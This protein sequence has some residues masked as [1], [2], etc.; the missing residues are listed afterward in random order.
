MHCTAHIIYIIRWRQ[1]FELPK[2]S[3]PT[4]IK[5]HTRG[6]HCAVFLWYSNQFDSGKQRICRAI[7]TRIVNC[8]FLRSLYQLF[9]CVIVRQSL[10]QVHSHGSFNQ[11]SFYHKKFMIIKLQVEIMGNSWFT[12]R[13]KKRILRLKWS[14]GAWSSNASCACFT[15]F[16][17]LSWWCRVN[18]TWS[19]NM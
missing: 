4:L 7:Q 18:P 16:L 2:R 17:S 11:S 6:S 3:L 12:T 9:A 8:F 14:T 15:Y 19:R 13:R 1:Y 10:S 5:A